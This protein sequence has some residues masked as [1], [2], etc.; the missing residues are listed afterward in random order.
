MDPDV[1]IWSQPGTS[2]IF[3][4]WCSGKKVTIFFHYKFFLGWCNVCN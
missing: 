1:K 2:N 3:W 4:H